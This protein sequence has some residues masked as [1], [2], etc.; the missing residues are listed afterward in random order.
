VIEEHEKSTPI[1]YI[2]DRLKLLIEHWLKSSKPRDEQVTFIISVIIV[3]KIIDLL[4][5]KLTSE[6]GKN[7]LTRKHKTVFN[8]FSG[9]ELT[10]YKQLWTQKSIE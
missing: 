8:E 5:P 3:L 1:N 10:I 7:R 4:I 6:S 2:H 9:N